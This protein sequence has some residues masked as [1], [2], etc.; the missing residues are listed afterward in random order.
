MAITC[1]ARSHGSNLKHIEKQTYTKLE[2]FGDLFGA[3]ELW[4]ESVLLSVC[5][6][7]RMSGA[8][9]HTSF[10]RPPDHGALILEM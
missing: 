8:R 9:Q 6:G 2:G 10:V 5:G 7:D 4:L 3:V 1:G